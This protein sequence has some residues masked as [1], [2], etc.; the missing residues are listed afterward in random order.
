MIAAMA[1]G[2]D[3]TEC[4][5]LETAAASLRDSKAAIPD[6]ETDELRIQARLTTEG[7]KRIS[8]ESREGEL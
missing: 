3:L 7:R 4:R 6:D 2:M 8:L 5:K 1:T